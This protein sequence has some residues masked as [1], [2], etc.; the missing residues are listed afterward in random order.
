MLDRPTTK[1]AWI[2]RARA[3]KPE[4]RAFINGRYV[5]ALSGQGAALVEKG[6][7]ER[8]RQ[9]LSRVRTLCKGTCPQ[10]TTLAA[11]IALGAA[12]QP[13]TF[14]LYGRLPGAMR[15]IADDIMRAALAAVG[16]K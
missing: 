4:G 1:E 10:A 2:A 9:N 13:A 12:L 15:D 8:A 11:A 3:T 5:D 14:K 16:A 6:A 7:V